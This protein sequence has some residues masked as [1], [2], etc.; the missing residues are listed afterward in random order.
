M[1]AMGWNEAHIEGDIWPSRVCM[2]YCFVTFSDGGMSSLPVLGNTR[3][4]S[5]TWERVL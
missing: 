1:A 4:A 3:S 2:S 5:Y